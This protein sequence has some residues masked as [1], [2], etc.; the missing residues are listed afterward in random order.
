[1]PRRARIVVPYH[2]YHVTQRGNY[3]QNIFQEDQDRVVYLKYIQEKSVLYGV[4]IYA[5]CLI[6]NHVHFLVKPHDPTALAN[7]FRTVHMKYSHYFNRINHQKGHLW[8]GRYYSC[9]VNGRHIIKVFRYV[10]NNPVRAGMVD[11][12]WEYTW[13]SARAHLGKEYK[14]ICLANV[15]EYIDLKSWKSYLSKGQSEQSLTRMRDI[16]RKGLML[17]SHDFVVKMEQRLAIN[18]IPNRR[19][20]PNRK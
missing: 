11:K 7:M 1:M 6:D 18:I 8:Q 19:G 10:E 5:Y 2:L 3:R 20:R 17:A 15:S 12:A 4:D 14:I 9:L 13:S 16:T